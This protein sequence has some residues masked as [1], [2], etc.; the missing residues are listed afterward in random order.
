MKVIEQTTSE[1]SGM[2]RKTVAM[3]RVIETDVPG[4]NQVTTLP[5]CDWT[6]VPPQ[7]IPA[8]GIEPPVE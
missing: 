6:P 5:L 2:M 8:A 3:Y 7:G 1:P 4:A